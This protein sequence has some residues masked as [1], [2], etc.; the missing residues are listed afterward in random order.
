MKTLLLLR[1]AKSG[2]K[3]ADMRDFDRP[4][5]MRGQRD[6]SVI[7]R[8]LRKH[9]IKPDALI[10]SPAERARETVNLIARIGKL[11]APLRFDE[12]IYEAHA[13]NLVEV[14][15]QIGEEF[16]SA[17]MVGHNP[18]FSDLVQH[19]TGEESPMPTAAL[20]QLSLDIDQ[21]KEVRPG[22]GELKRMTKPKDIVKS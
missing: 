9:S 16:S 3:D 15:S 4:L 13:G 21:W 20:A 12:R 2:W 8:Y 6:A 22:C 19:L 5:T 1:H 17:L 10:S 11:Q 18:G 7:S 14:V